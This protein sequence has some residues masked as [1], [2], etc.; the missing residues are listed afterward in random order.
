MENRLYRSETNKMIA[1]VC[2]GLGDYFG[3]DPV[4]VR[5]VFVLLVFAS[6]IGLLAYVILW[7]IVPTAS[8]AGQPAEAVMRE[9]I[10]E[11]GERA[12]ELG[13]EVQESLRREPPSPE[14]QEAQAA[15][16]RERRFWFG[17]I[18][19]LIGLLFLI[20]NLNLL[21]WL[22]VGRLWPLIIVIIGIAFLLRGRRGRP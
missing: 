9:N 20:S 1:G 8:R 16:Q 12:R 7:I 11:M 6:G 17:A 3:I 22:E 13:Q 14:E 19:I 18:L 10:R 21:W 15:R 4:L 5:L 2:G